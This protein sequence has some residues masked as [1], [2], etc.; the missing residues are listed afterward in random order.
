[1][2]AALVEGGWLQRPGSVLSSA[3]AAQSAD[4]GAGSG[5]SE[6]TWACRCSARSA[7]RAMCVQWKSTAAETQ[8]GRRLL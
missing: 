4:L 7:I 6:L 1:M 8:M 3:I 5:G 2:S